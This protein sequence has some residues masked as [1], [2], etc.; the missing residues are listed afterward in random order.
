MCAAFGVSQ[1]DLEP[2]TGGSS[3]PVW[4]AGSKR[5][6]LKPVSN[7]AEAAWVAQTLDALSV[8]GVRLARP[9]R[10]S[11]G[12]WVVGG[13]TA[14]R[15]V[16][17][18]PEPRHDEVVAVSLRL[19]QAVAGVPRPRFLAH[20]ADVYADADRSAW[21]ES[22]LTIDDSDGGSEFASLA[23]LR[24]PVD[25]RSQLVHGD[26]CSNVLFA[27]SAPPAIID[28]AP[29]WRP[30]E[31]AAAVIVIDALAWGGADPGLVKRWAHLADWPQCLVRALLFRLAA[32]ALHPRSPRGSLTGLKHATAVIR[33]FL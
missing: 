8:P 30:P 21:G 9:M 13:W 10:S 17:G 7:T 14:A 27:G 33:P 12:R 16:A 19:H 20:R 6:V 23:A 31:W 15:H 29:Y 24:R 26:L 28:F 4:L 22:T 5:L 11:D 1:D 25:L 3:G 2:L 18:R 32:H